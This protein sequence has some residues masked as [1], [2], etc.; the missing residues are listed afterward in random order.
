M[1]N[2]VTSSNASA[3]VTAHSMSVMASGGCSSADDTPALY[4]NS[5][6][7]EMEQGG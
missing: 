5:S 4:C 6:A 1:A 7:V 2:V 3:T